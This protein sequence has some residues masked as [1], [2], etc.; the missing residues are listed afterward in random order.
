MIEYLLSLAANIIQ[1][2]GPLV[3]LALMW[4][5][6]QKISITAVAEDGRR[7]KLKEL[8][9]RQVTEAEI[10]GSVTRRVQGGGRIDVSRFPGLPFKFGR[11]VEFPL[12]DADFDSLR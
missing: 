4:R 3:I 5:D 8:E 2:G 9:R 7:K 1:V 6:H 11:E 10:V 12:S